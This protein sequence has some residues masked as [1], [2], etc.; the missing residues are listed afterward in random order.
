M[1]KTKAPVLLT[2][3]GKVELAVQQAESYQAILE[4]KDGRETIE[5]IRRGL[6]S[7][8][9]QQGEAATDFF[10]EFFAAKGIPEHE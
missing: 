5:G 4:T 2:V 8:K 9:Q 3:N 10:R 7:M 6:E 1:K